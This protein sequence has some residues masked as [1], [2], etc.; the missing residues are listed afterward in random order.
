MTGHVVR[1]L[2]SQ[3]PV[4]IELALQQVMAEAR[5]RAGMTAE[6]FARAINDR[7]P[8]P[9]GLKGGAILAYED[10]QVP[11]PGDVLCRALELAGH[12]ATAALV[13][14]VDGVSRPYPLPPSGLSARRASGESRP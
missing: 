9:L 5:R 12:D 4:T 6:A 7:S 14:W 3:P 2:V 10:G 11:P 8:K 1:L 13:D